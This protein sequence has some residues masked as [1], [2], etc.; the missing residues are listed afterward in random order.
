MKYNDKTVLYIKQ[1]TTTTFVETLVK[2]SL[3]TKLFGLYYDF[4]ISNK[5][6]TINLYCN[7]F[8]NAST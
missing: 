5:D 1:T 2:T 8:F 7:S 3:G 6:L 4:K